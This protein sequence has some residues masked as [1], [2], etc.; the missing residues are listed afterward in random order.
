V[1]WAG[2]AV[3]LVMAAV[4][5]A[6]GL[7]KLRAPRETATTLRALLDHRLPRA[8]TLARVLGAAESGTAVV[9]AFRPIAYLGEVFTAALAV[10]FAAT[11]LMALR[12]GKRVSC[13]CFGGS[14]QGVLGRRQLLLLPLWLTGC[15][16]GAAWR[17]DGAPV[18]LEAVAALVT[19]VGVVAVVSLLRA[20]RAAVGDRQAAQEWMRPA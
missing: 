11:G 9:L 1:T 2:A 20:L 15:V 3:E 5:L 7:A 17:T 12:T 10:G 19:L 14:G 8:E 16:A 6:A 13:S 18:G 4:L